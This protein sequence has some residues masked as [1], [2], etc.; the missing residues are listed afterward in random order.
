[1]SVIMETSSIDTGGNFT[2][3]SSGYGLPAYKNDCSIFLLSNSYEYDIELITKLSM[4]N[5]DFRKVLIPFR[6][7]QKVDG[8]PINFNITK[9]AFDDMVSYF[10][11]ISKLNPE[12]EIVQQ[13][14]P[15]SIKDN[16]YIP[17][18]QWFTCANNAISDKSPQWITD[19]IFKLIQT[20][21][22]DYNYSMH[23]YLVV[24]YEHFRIYK[25]PNEASMHKDLINALLYVCVTQPEAFQKMRL[26][27]WFK[28]K[29][30]YKF[31]MTDFNK[32]YVP[33]LIDMIN[34]IGVPQLAPHPDT[35]D[36][37]PMNDEE[38][39]EDNKNE[40]EQDKTG[41]DNS[42]FETGEF[43][44]RNANPLGMTRRLVSSLMKKFNINSNDVILDTMYRAKSA[45]NQ[46][47]LSNRSMA[48][49]GF[50]AAAPQP[51]NATNNKNIV[52]SDNDSVE[53]RMLNTAA[54]E[55]QGVEKT[56]ELDTFNT[57]SS[58]R[59]TKIR[60]QVEQVKLKDQSF[61]TI[62]SVVDVAK[63]APARQANVTSTNPAAQKGVQFANVTKEYENK[64]MARD[65]V[66][67]LMRLSKI[68]DGFYVTD[69]HVEDVSSAVSLLENWK[70][71]FRNKRTE[72]V[73]NVSIMIPKLVDGR[74][75]LN[76]S[77]YNIGKQDFP[78]PILKVSPKK[79]IITTN[80][81]KIT[82]ERY[83]TRSLVDV[84]AFSKTIAQLTDKFNKKYI[85]VGCNAVS[86]SSYISTI[87]YDEYAKKWHAF[88]NP[89]T[90]IEVLFNRSECLKKYTYVS[91]NDDEFCCGSIDN[92]PIVINTNTGLTRQ[93][94]SLT[95]VMLSGLP[96]EGYDIYMKMKPGKV[97]M[98]TQITVGVVVPLGVACAAWEG[99]NSLIKKSGCKYQFVNNGFND[100][101][102]FT[103]P[104][105]D[106]I[107]AIEGTVPNQLLF[108]GFM[109]IN[110]RVYTFAQMN[111]PISETE[112]VY[113]DM[114]NQLFFKQYSQLTT[115]ITTYNF[116]VD[117]ITEDVCRHYNMPDD[118][119]SMLIYSSN[120]L[121]D[122]SLS[123][124][125][126]ASLYRIRSSEIVPAIVHY[127]LAV[128]MSKYNNRLGSRSKDNALVV[129]PNDVIN[130]LSTGVPNVTPASAL[131]PMNELHSREEITKKGFKGVNSDRAFTPEKRAYHDSM[132]GKIALSSPNNKNVGVNR[133]L[134][135]DPKIESVRGYTSSVGIEGEYNDFQLASPSELFTPG[136]VTRD[137][138]IR[139][140]I[141]TS[142]TGH[143]VST[144]V[145]QPV[146]VSNGFDEIAPA[147][148][149]EEFTVVAE[150]DGTVVEI[151]DG[152]MICQYN[153]GK[154]RAIPMNDKYAFNGGGGFYVNNKLIN[155]FAPGEKFKK[156]D[157]LAYHE[158]FFTKCH[159]GVVRTNIGPIVKVA[160]TGLYSTYEDGGIITAKM[161]RDMGSE[162][163][164]MEQ[165]KLSAMDDV[166]SIVK[167]GDEVE[168]DDP[169]ITFGLGVSGD[170]SVD[171]FLKAFATS[172]SGVDLGSAAKR[173]LTSK[174]AG[175]VVDVRMYS[176]VSMDKLSPSLFNILSQHYKEN[177]QKQNILNKHDKTNTTYKMGTLFNKP[178]E[179]LKGTSIKGIT[180]DVLIEIFISH[181]DECGVGDKAVMY[182]A[183][184]QVISEMIPEGLEPYSEYRP[185]E[186][187]SMLENP[188]AVMKRMVPSL[189]I[190]AT[191]NKVLIETKRQIKAIYEK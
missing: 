10:N 163:I 83:D 12:I 161:S 130:I 191:A 76:G 78:I 171:N 122:N 108:N 45:K 152:Y 22:F 183:C 186:E 1:M 151:T 170:K 169:L 182:G 43:Q 149:T 61:K 49:G 134:V 30:E 165:F 155:S 89:E 135:A 66:A 146:L 28:G 168:I 139:T 129:N 39:E 157:I 90:G 137:D 132:V 94:E 180:T 159:D 127:I 60:E 109:K 189:L 14:Y 150:D 73:S 115:F 15:F 104:F 7:A 172:S 102:Y 156:N 48:I 116:M 138:A 24:D 55:M 176:C 75:Y 173:V 187:V 72:K 34:E 47:E 93:G 162:I 112:S 37:V 188:Y 84:T 181:V 8:E 16:L 71:T 140:A 86:N 167:I 9:P 59:E 144:K 128:A 166:E 178:T 52:S 118:L 88:R 96:Q 119:V 85:D 177:R 41:M 64:L 70:I 123:S 185:D 101:H 6:S 69:V 42:D 107:L 114:F 91:V 4:P 81:N 164:M 147:M 100:P 174:H 92:K 27:I 5:D 51:Q 57:S 190:T 131:N 184:K 113:V 154:K 120:L 142:Q 148:L 179:P 145:A 126:T 95:A 31:D 63:P 36:D 35:V 103:I 62:S 54:S 79:I 143:I 20:M 33:M 105:K 74:F 17:F 13:P 133:Q 11:S 50:T 25:N 158:K 44:K 29:K 26:T 19:N 80:Y 38:D 3:M 77:W 121:A 124:E 153:N 87:E 46:V 82:V 98:Y 160:F 68:P 111:V 2:Y 18:T 136:T 110:T 141:A 106:R 56:D 23:K 40:I 32:N 65:I 21:F 175:T 117:V 125:L 99:I 67:T 53:D 97:N 58:P